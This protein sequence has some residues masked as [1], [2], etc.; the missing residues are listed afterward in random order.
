MRKALHDTSRVVSC[1]DLTGYDG[2]DLERI[3]DAR[4]VALSDDQ[5]L[6]MTTEKRPSPIGKGE[7]TIEEMDH[8]FPVHGLGGEMGLTPGG[9][10]NKW[11]KIANR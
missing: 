5:L 9:R 7:C 3:L 1:K 10:P 8:I 6:F 2:A 4:R 11:A